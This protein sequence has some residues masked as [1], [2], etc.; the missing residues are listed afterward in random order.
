[1]FSVEGESEPAAA[2][3]IQHCPFLGDDQVPGDLGL[4]IGEHLAHLALLGDAA[5]VDDR[6]PVADLVDDLHLMGDNHDGD[7]Q[8]VVDLPQQLQNGAGGIGV[9]GAGSLVAEQ[10]LGACCQSSGNGNALLLSSGELGRIGIGPV[11]K[12]HH[13]QQLHGPRPGLFPAHAG[14]LQRI[15]D[16]SQHASLGQQVEA[17]KDHAD[18]LPKLQKL[19]PGKLCHAFPIN[20]NLAVRRLLKQ[21]DTA[22]KGA[23]PGAGQADDAEDLTVVYGQVDIL[24]GHDLLFLGAVG[25]GQVF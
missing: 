20:D 3:G 19:L 12:T 13:V 5:V 7:A 18:R 10:I 25:L 6:H 2:G 1:M 17:L 8:T 21:V 11:G 4:G 24:Q 22:D 23:F 14:D 9:K 16:V 15:A